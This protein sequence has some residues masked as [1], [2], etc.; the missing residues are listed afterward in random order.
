MKPSINWRPNQPTVSPRSIRSWKPRELG[1]KPCAKKTAATLVRSMARINRQKKLPAARSTRL[2][3][4]HARP[5]PV[6][7]KLIARLWKISSVKCWAFPISAKPFVDQAVG[8]L[9]KDANDA[10][11]EQT[12]KLA[13]QLFD[14]Q[15]YS[16]A[17]KV[18]DDLSRQLERLTDK[19]AGIYSGCRWPPVRQRFGRT[20][21]R[22]RKTG[23]CSLRPGRSPAEA[24]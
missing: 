18:V 5:P 1:L 24:K 4:P 20:A 11:R 12:R 7:W 22:S 15:A 2:K 6:S 13:A 8:R 14:S 17:Q 21:R 3:S 9:S 16:E 10:Q 23:C 19:R